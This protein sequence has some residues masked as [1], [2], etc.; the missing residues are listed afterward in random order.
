MPSSVDDPLS[1]FRVILFKAPLASHHLAGSHKWLL[2]AKL[3]Q[4]TGQR[5]MG[6]THAILTT[7]SAC[8]C[9]D[10]TSHTHSIMHHTSGLPGL[11]VGRVLAA[12]LGRH[13]PLPDVA[14]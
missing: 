9:N 14:V 12:V 13:A 11:A 10:I 3:R 1:V 7:L 2:N 8:A 5:V 6:Y 4:A